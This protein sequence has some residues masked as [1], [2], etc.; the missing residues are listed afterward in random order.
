[1][2]AQAEKLGFVTALLELPAMITKKCPLN[3]GRGANT[4]SVERITNDQRVFDQG[5]APDPSSD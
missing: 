2:A 3:K 4:Y 1:M 5:L